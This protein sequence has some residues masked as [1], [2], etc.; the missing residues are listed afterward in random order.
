MSAR[1]S[2]KSQPPARKLIGRAAEKRLTELEKLA[3]QFWPGRNPEDRALRARMVWHQLEAEVDW[4][5]VEERTPL[6]NP[7]EVTED[8]IAEICTVDLE[9]AL[10]ITSEGYGDNLRA[11][12]RRQ[13]RSLEE[14][15][16]TLKPSREQVPWEELPRDE[17]TGTRHQRQKVYRELRKNMV[18]PWNR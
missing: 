15:C 13:G 9:P 17:S 4:H 11:E 5:A 12:F 14:F 18:Y 7:I 6:R 16:L 1:P 2:Y 8:A 3:D 10:G